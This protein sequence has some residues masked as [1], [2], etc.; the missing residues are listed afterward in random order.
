MPPIIVRVRPRRYYGD[1][2]S[3]QERIDRGVGYIATREKIEERQPVNLA[4]MLRA[5]PGVDVVQSGSTLTGTFDIRMRNAQNMLGETCPP[6]VW[7]DGVKWRDVR[8]AYTDI[9]GMELEV[10]EVYNGPAQVPGEFL[11]SDA[12]CGAIIVWTRRGRM[13]GG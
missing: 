5:I 11:D 2:V 12:S 1:M 4:D 13:F 8:S 6:A 7:V 10:V 9:S 3:L